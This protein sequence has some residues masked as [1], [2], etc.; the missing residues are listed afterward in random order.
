MTAP[1]LDIVDDEAGLL[2]MGPAWDDLLS[3]SSNDSPFAA[4]MW[5]SAW[6]R[7]YGNDRRRPRV[8]VYT[9]PDTSRLVGLLPLYEER[10]R[11]PLGTRSLR[12]LCDIVSAG[13]GPLVE[14]G[15]EAEMLGRMAADLHDGPIA[16]DVVD[17][18]LMRDG[19]P[20]I[21]ALTAASGRERSVL[22]PGRHVCPRVALPADWDTYMR[23]LSKGMRR[24]IRHYRAEI[25]RA[26]IELERIESAQEVPR[27]IDDLIA[28]FELRMREKL[29]RRFAVPAA[30]DTFLRHVSEG[31]LEAGAL[32]L[33][34]FTKEG[35]RIA[36]LYQFRHGD[37]MYLMQQ[38]YDP[39]FAGLR[40][41]TVLTSYAV[42]EAMREGCTMFDF[43][44]G[45]D[46]HKF[47]WGV[48]EV[49]AF[50]D[51]HLYSGTAAGIARQRFD[52]AARLAA[53]V[54]KSAPSP[55]QERVGTWVRAARRAKRR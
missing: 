12:Y 37:T 16:W 7:A 30:Y 50:S 10:G 51:L 45:A 15:L 11:M 36:F 1:R 17:L 13:N 9:D 34:F 22:E 31:L 14:R 25:D 28:L 33:W 42:E 21:E 48:S 20:F 35:R 6:W 40:P 32:R 47:R 46:R 26:G 23:G 5:A 29:N 24:K 27:A 54:V 38:A 44:L 39:T 18:R 19:S 2:A 4:H 41:S 8:L 55:V 43:L 3:R 52:G 53:S 49:P